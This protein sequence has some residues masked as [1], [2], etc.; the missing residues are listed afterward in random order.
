MITDNG[1]LG[2][3]FVIVTMCFA[4]NMWHSSLPVPKPISSK[5]IL[6]KSK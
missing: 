2:F 4:I 1:P 6:E 3:I 5:L